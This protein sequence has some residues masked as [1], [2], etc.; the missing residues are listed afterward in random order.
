M[1]NRLLAV[2]TT[3]C[4]L[5]QSHR[6]LA[7]ENL[8]LR[9]QLA[10]LKS[11]VK[12]PRASALDRLFWVLFAKYVNRWRAMLH[13]LHP[14]TVVRWHREG[15][16]RYWRW[17]SQRR[18]V[19]R[20]PINR[21]IRSLIHDMQSANV[22][23]GAPRIHG[24]LLKLGIEIS[25]ATVSKYMA[26]H[27]N[28]PSQTWRT[29]LN[30]HVTDLASIDFFTVPT[31]TF[32]ILYVFIVLRHDRRQIVHFNVTAHPTAQWTAQQIVEA[33]PF[34]TVPRYLLRDRDAIYGKTVQRRIKSLAI[35]DVLTAPRSPW[36]NPFVERVIGS[37][38][39]DCLDHVI[40]LNERQ[41]RRILREYLGYYHSCRT[42]LSLSKDSP[43]PRAIQPPDSGKV[44]AFPLVGGLHH[45][46]GR[47]AA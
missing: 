39:R 40:V 3:F 31:A 33:F 13:T 30:N 25:Q 1:L 44:T 41:L 37:I 34:D 5:F 22:G 20:P 14:D 23:W 15:F 7:L 38:R 12:R 28:P 18:R 10:M 32:R 21:E 42:H 17:K 29:F 46:Y 19:G 47:L 9:Q 6:R 4:S 16:R 8:A 11:S 2:L 35:E 43:K 24:E 45:R 36:Q 26:R 27:R